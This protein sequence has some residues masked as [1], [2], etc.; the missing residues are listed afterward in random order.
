MTSDP[1][2][3]WAGLAQQAEAAYGIPA[4][5]LLGLTKI[6]SGGIEGRT[7]SAGAGG[8]T[9][10]TPPTAR[11]YNVDVTPG[12]AP[13]QIFG[14]AK[15]LRDL[16]FTKDPE[17]ALAKYN[18]G[19]HNPAAG[20]GYAKDVLAA[21]EQYTHLAK[22]PTPTASTASTPTSSSSGGGG[23]GLVNDDRRK[24]LTKAL[25][26]VALVSTGAGALWIGA[27]QLIHPSGAPA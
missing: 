5:V 22:A 6:E 17:L 20:A 27:H 16:E 19:P 13:S 3:K 15:Y 21:A 1:V 8:L 2:L 26:A 25:L 4:S 24:G 10:F 7:S 23:G 18:A 14:A 9:Q 11:D 12:H